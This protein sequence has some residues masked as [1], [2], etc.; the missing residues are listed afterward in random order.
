MSEGLRAEMIK[1]TRNTLEKAFGCAKRLTGSSGLLDAP[2]A[3]PAEGGEKEE[4]AE[5][6][7]TVVEDGLFHIPSEAAKKVWR[8]EEV[9]EGNRF[10][11]VQHIFQDKWDREEILLLMQMQD[12]WDAEGSGGGSG[13]PARGPRRRL[14]PPRPTIWV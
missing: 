2:P 9:M 14:P 5:G 1:S 4:E 10:K 6:G 7:D 11:L 8:A 3:S 12:E 13:G